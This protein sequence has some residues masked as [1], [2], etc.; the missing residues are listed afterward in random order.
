MH[1]SKKIIF[2]RPGEIRQVKCG[3]PAPRHLSE[4]VIRPGELLVVLCGSLWQRFS[5]ACGFP[6]RLRIVW[7]RKN[8]RIRVQCKSTKD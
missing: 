6:N 2:L 1:L 5:F 4:F 7:V 8:R 3:F